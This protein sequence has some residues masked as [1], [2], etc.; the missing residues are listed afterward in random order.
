MQG[1]SLDALNKGDITKEDI[2]EAYKTLKHL[3]EKYASNY[4]Y[5]LEQAPVPVSYECSLRCR[6]SIISAGVTTIGVLG[7]CFVLPVTRYASSLERATS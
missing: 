7:K 1:C 5:L 4:D 6:I 2:D 3:E